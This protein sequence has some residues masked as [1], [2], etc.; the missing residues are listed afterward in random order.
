[1][2]NMASP[3]GF[4]SDTCSFAASATTIDQIF[5]DIASSFTVARLIPDDVN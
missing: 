3:G 5:A 4:Y 1:M 2:Q